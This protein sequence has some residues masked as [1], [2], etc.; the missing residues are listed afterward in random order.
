MGC[1]AYLSPYYERGE[2][3]PA[4]ENDEFYDS[5]LNYGGYNSAS[6]YYTLTND[7]TKG[8]TLMSDGNHKKYTV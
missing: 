3:V 6:A 5:A 4:D 8:L 1:R 2:L 7:P